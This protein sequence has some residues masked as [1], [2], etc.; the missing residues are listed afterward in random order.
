MNRLNIRLTRASQYLSQFEL[1]V[2]Y[3]PGREH[4]LPDAISR[5]ASTTV[6]KNDGEEILNF[7]ACAENCD[8][9]VSVFL[10]GQNAISD[11]ID[12]YGSAYYV[13]LVKMAEEEKKL[14]VQGYQDNSA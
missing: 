8:E 12:F 6:S 3:K 5:L 7:L 10:N 13:T 2:R 14:V 1:D 4:I 9:N 11:R